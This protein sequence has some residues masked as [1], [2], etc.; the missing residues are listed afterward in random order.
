MSIV[1]ALILL[2]GAFAY[3]TWRIPIT[4]D[5]LGSWGFAHSSLGQLI[6][7]TFAQ[8]QAPLYFTAL[9]LWRLLVGDSVIGLRLLSLLL[10]V[11]TLITVHLAS[12][13]M[14]GKRVAG[15]VTLFFSGSSL[16]WLYGLLARPY[17]LG[18]FLEAFILFL[19][20]LYARR[21]SWKALAFSGIAA[22]ALVL[23][24][25]FY[26]IPLPLMA[27]FTGVVSRRYRR[28]FY[29]SLC[30]GIGC[31]V[32]VV[33]LLPL[34]S[35]NVTGLHGLAYREPPIWDDLTRA[36]IT[37]DWMPLAVSFLFFR[38]VRPRVFMQSKYHCT[39]QVISTGLLTAVFP[40]LV[41]FGLSS[42]TGATLFLDRYFSP[43]ILFSALSMGVILS[44]F[45]RKA[46]CIA[47]SVL[48]VGVS[49]AHAIVTAETSTRIEG[50]TNEEQKEIL[51][52]VHV[53]ACPLFASTGFIET[54]S[55]QKLLNPNLRPFLE[56]PIRF[57]GDEDFTLLPMKVYPGAVVYW[58]N[59]IEP[60]LKRTMCADIIATNFPY[61]KGSS[62]PLAVYIAERLPELGFR[63]EIYDS[64]RYFLFVR[65]IRPPHELRQSIP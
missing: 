63:F 49:I 20:I 12:R 55:T 47:L 39:T 33:L 46:F 40:L 53:A 13:L 27:V 38:L 56:A 29:W 36:I 19:A 6:Q 11:A 61:P 34:F 65:A 9:W 41:L 32:G 10:A 37:T 7:A 15:F 35:Q 24:H 54:A 42:Y 16:F 22:A 28:C 30:V 14:F 3:T 57:F 23:T 59:E 18:N 31:A 48:A 5:E 62:E 51:R 60:V 43:T 52:N 58:N 45:K 64:H 17:A 50:L 2:V 8:G 26:L 4:L 21:G 25:F 1:P 44:T